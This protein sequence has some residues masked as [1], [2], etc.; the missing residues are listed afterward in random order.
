MGAAEATQIEQ[1]W[2][3]A[4]SPSMSASAAAGMQIAIWK[5]IGAGATGGAT[6][7]LNSANDYG[8]AGLLTWL[9]SNSSAPRANLL[10]LTGPGQDYVIPNA[11][12]GG[13]HGGSVPDGGAT[14]MLLGG[15]LFGLAIFRRKLSTT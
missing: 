14:L 7:T 1:L 13:G 4:Y 11:G 10:G 5:I 9:S 12:G 3:Y 8:A 2:L 15:S 6:F